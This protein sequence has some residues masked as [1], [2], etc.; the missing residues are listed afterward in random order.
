[1]RSRDICVDVAAIV[2]PFPQHVPGEEDWHAVEEYEAVAEHREGTLDELRT[3]WEE[4][5][6]DPLLAALH[7]A[8]RAKEQ[9]ENSIRHLIAYGREFVQPRPYT[10]ADLAAAAGMS[11]SGVR[12]A[13]Q[14]DDVDAVAQTT[15]AR[16]R[17]W[18]AP[19]PQPQSQDPT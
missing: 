14:S 8:R 5:D 15:G 7:S 12:T 19:D 4:G 6:Q 16:H 2:N 18:R 17:D 9:A 1:M 10:L 13:Y 3:A 11:V